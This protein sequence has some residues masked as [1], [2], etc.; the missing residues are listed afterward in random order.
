MKEKGAA[1]SVFPKNTKGS[2]KVE[3]A[4]GM[5]AVGRLGGALVPSESAT[6]REKKR[7]I[8]S[9]EQR[10]LLAI[11]DKM[12][13]SQ[14]SFAA[15]IGIS[16]DKLVNIEN[17]RILNIEDEI[18]QPAREL[19]EDPERLN[20]VERLKTANMNDLV[21]EWWTKLGLPLDDPESDKEGADLIGV[22]ANSV[23]R[24]RKGMAR[25]DPETLMRFDR[26]TERLS[27]QL[28]VS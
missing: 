28:K 13:L 22:H 1:G 21:N 26:L 19:I 25:P 24:W 3:R 10:E 15:A 5:N 20:A 12:G 6:R 7:R 23:Y 11:R 27:K 18:M 8:R 14:A 4:S 17:G 2:V 16:R 9:P